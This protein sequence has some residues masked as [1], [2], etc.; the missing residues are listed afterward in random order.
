[1]DRALCNSIAVRATGKL[2]PAHTCRPHQTTIALCTGCYSIPSPRHGSV[3]GEGTALDLQ[4]SFARA[5]R[6]RWRGTQLSNTVGLRLHF[7][8]SSAVLPN[9]IV[10]RAVRLTWRDLTAEGEESGL[11]LR[12]EVIGPQ[13]SLLN[14]VEDGSMC[15]KS[16]PFP[17]QLEHDHTPAPHC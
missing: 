17:L 9:S 3:N 6:S 7:A 8:R 10:H 4:R 16:W 5:L 14:V 13:M 2:S 12:L 15:S 11:P 1:M